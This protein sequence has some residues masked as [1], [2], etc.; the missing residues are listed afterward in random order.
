MNPFFPCYPPLERTTNPEFLNLS[1]ASR[2]LYPRQI[3]LGTNPHAQKHNLAED[4]WWSQVLVSR[5]DK[6]QG[7]PDTYVAVYPQ[8]SNGFG[9]PIYMKILHLLGALELQMRSCPG[10]C[11]SL[12]ESHISRFRSEQPEVDQFH[13]KVSSPSYSVTCSTR[14]HSCKYSVKLSAIMFRLDFSPI[15]DYPIHPPLKLSSH[16]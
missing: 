3:G 14:S 10:R 11:S 7:H 6:Q 16:P 2:K 9:R 5:G 8:S 12:K 13:L 4:D 15:D 1:M